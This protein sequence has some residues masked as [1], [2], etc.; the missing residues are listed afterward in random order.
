M[1]SHKDKIICRKKE[2]IKSIPLN[3]P[4]V[5]TKETPFDL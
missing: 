5:D 3:Q 1:I 2:V 4:N